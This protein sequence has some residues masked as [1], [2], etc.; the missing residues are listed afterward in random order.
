[1][2]TIVRSSGERPP[3]TARQA[4]VLAY[5]REHAL[6]FGYSPSV[7]DIGEGV[8]LTSSGTVQHHLDELEAKGY[9]FRRGDRKSIR[10]LQAG[11][12]EQA[13]PVVPLVG[14][15]AAGMPL[16]AVENI[17]DYIPVPAGTLRVVEGCFALRVIGDSMAGAG[18]L[19]GDLVI[20]RPQPDAES[21]AIVVARLDIEATG[22][23]EVTVKRLHRGKGSIE[24]VA[25]NP[26]YPPIDGASAH[27]EGIVVGLIRA[28]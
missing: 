28:Y 7:R 25:E 17:E 20:V 11:L 5:I 4:D 27:V 12:P 21:R 16:L 23:S 15:V 10:V 2:H 13:V 26:A 9:I 3:L 8:G 14:R 6:S 24:L 22:E 19:D 18:I 1:M